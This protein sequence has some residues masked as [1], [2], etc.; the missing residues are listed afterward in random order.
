M[1]EVEFLFS[2]LVGLCFLAVSVMVATIR[3]WQS[4]NREAKLRAALRGMR[5]SVQPTVTVLVYIQDAAQN[6]E[7]AIRA[8]RKNRY[9]VIDVVLI[10]DSQNA[11]VE[12]RIDAIKGAHRALRR[13]VRTTRTAA[14]QAGYKKSMKGEVVISIDGGELVDTLFVKR[15]IAQKGTRES[16]RVHTNT[17]LAPDITMTALT[18]RLE[19]LLWHQHPEIYAYTKRA[20][21]RLDAGR[22]DFNTAKALLAVNCTLLASVLFGAAFVAGPQLLWY[23][24]VIL[25]TYCL[26]IVWFRFGDPLRDRIVLTLSVPLALILVPTASAMRNISQ[27]NLPK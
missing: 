7:D 19:A 10:D 27:V 13:R 26:V 16:W 20:F 12:Q 8:I 11:E 25:T 14:L 17:H 22:D 18:T 9:G 2:L 3:Q 21:L 1:S 5:R 6:F 23:A 4:V 15:L 24:W